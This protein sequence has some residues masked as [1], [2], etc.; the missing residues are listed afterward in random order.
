[1]QA[2]TCDIDRTIKDARNLL[3]SYQN[4]QDSLKTYIEGRLKEIQK[5]QRNQEPQMEQQPR[6]MTWRPSRFR[7]QTEAEDHHSRKCSAASN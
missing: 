5:S 1:V 7:D 3:R 6:Y 2:V 4:E